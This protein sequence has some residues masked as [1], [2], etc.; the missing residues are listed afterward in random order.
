MSQIAGV[1]TGLA[2]GLIPVYPVHAVLLIACAIALTYS[3]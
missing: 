1:T 2:L 3:R